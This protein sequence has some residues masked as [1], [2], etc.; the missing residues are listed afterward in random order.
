M[1]KEKQKLKKLSALPKIWKDWKVGDGYEI[2]KQI[3]SGS[4]GLVIEAIRKSTG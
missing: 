3:G 4:Y 1:E 2:K